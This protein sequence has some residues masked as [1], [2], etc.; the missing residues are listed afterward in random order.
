MLTEYIKNSWDECIRFS[1]QDDGTLIGMPYPYIVPTKKKSLQEMYYWD[2]FFTCKGLILSG[3]SEVAKN[4][5]DDMIFMVN[6]Y[7]FMPNG[8]RTYYLTQSQPPFL[9]MMIRDV[10]EVYKDIEWLKEA[11]EALKKE[12]DFWM[13]ERITDIGLNTFKVNKENII[14]E[15]KHYESI[16]RR[17]SYQV[18]MDDHMEFAQSFLTD[19][20]SG[21]DFNPRTNMK[22][23]QNIY[24]DLNGNLYLYEK[25]F[26]FFA[27]ILGNCEEDLWE[28]KAEKRKALMNKYLW[29][30][31]AFVDYNFI[32]KTHSDVFSVASFYPLWA[33]VADAKQAA[34]TVKML[35]KIEF[36]Y[37]V[38]ACCKND[39][40]GKY[41][42]GYG[43]GWAPLQ[44][45]V[46]R[47]LDN[48]GYEADA[49]RIAKKYID[50]TEKMFKETDELWE[51]YNVFTG[52]K[53]TEADYAS[54]P[55]MGWSAGV[56]LYAKDYIKNAV[57][58]ND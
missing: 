10:F 52:N 47:A 55:M 39:V 12:Y 29:N 33:G 3:R 57:G 41:Q 37:G 58:K 23:K 46:I 50:V 30:G 18:P 32:E 36:E 34:A 6:K 16:C 35:N 4:C 53:N 19:C 43:T 40:L 31:E 45:I 22:Q 20:E 14:N 26:A 9:S 15:D 25:N 54:R 28:E 13:K 2:T 17:I 51:K 8:N 42:W 5:T 44:Y 24:V 49:K 48:Y 1:P 7:G 56:Y 27:K 38:S 21:W 11:Y